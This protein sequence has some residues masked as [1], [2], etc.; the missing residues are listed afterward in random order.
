MNQNIK[1]NEPNGLVA[2]K[3]VDS[4]IP[5]DRIRFEKSVS[6]YY[7]R[8]KVKGSSKLPTYIEID[9]LI[10]L[11]SFVKT[12]NELLEKI[13]HSTRDL[14]LSPF[15]GNNKNGIRR[16]RL[17]YAFARYIISETIEQCRC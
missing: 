4:T 2:L 17:D 14:I 7:S 10:N 9:G 3:A 5:K 6:F 15:K 11:N 12:A 16:R 8:S 13:R 1:F